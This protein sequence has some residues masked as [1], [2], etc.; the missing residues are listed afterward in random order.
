[1]LRWAGSL[2]GMFAA[3]SLGLVVFG[4]TVLAAVLSGAWFR[5]GRAG[6]V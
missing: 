4:L 5:T 3:L 1:M 2:Y 6:N